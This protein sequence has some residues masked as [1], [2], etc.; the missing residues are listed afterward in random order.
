MERG[1]SL[2]DKQRIRSVR[3]LPKA[4]VCA[5]PC[6]NGVKILFRVWQHLHIAEQAGMANLTNQASS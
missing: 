6:T 2:S 4:L 1:G 5:I 3:W